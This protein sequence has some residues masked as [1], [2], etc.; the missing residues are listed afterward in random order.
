MA[1]RS[2]KKKCLLTARIY[3]RRLLSFCWCTFHRA[4][5][6]DCREAASA[7]EP[8]RAV[9][10]T[11]A[12]G[13]VFQ[14]EKCRVSQYSPGPVLD[15]ENLLFM[16]TDPQI[17]ML[18]GRIHPQS[19]KLVYDKGISTLRESAQDDEF[20]DTWEALTVNGKRR[21][22]VGVFKFSAVSIRK[23]DF[24]RK[25]GVFDTGELSRPNHADVIAMTA[26]APSRNEMERL[27]KAASDALSVAAG[28][29]YISAQ[30]FRNGIF[31]EL[32]IP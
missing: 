26:I 30:D 11:A 31:K 14:C 10:F 2:S 3:L 28:S 25:F 20:I 8:E 21:R 6:K 24:P 5:C 16:V 27:K 22:F 17:K 7:P 13:G 1:S 18:D 29:D 19:L 9:K 15:A 32:Q 4:T 12:C 23:S